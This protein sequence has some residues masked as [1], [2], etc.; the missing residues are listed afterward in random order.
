MR[1]EVSGLQL[2][3]RPNLAPHCRVPGSRGVAASLIDSA[4]EGRS[5]TGGAQAVTESSRY[6]LAWIELMCIRGC[7]MRV[8]EVNNH[9]PGWEK[10]N[11][12]AGCNLAIVTL[13]YASAAGVLGRLAIQFLTPFIL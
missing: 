1:R 4:A 13:H 6:A 9:E 2:N 10:I 11:P 12:M 5:V 8:T 7:A 3:L